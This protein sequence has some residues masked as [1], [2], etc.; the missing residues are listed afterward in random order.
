MQFSFKNVFKL[1]YIILYFLLFYFSFLLIN[2]HF[3]SNKNVAE[4]DGFNTILTY[5][6]DESLE[7]LILISWEIEIQFFFTLL[8]NITGLDLFHITV[9]HL[10]IKMPMIWWNKNQLFLVYLNEFSLNKL[11][12]VLIKEKITSLLRVFSVGN[13]RRKLLWEFYT[14]SRE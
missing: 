3:N 2:I 14:F 13:L 4:V 10:R 7:N 5:W 8:Y 11:I 12:K 1:H 9:I 6:I